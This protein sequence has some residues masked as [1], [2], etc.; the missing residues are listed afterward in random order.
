[1]SLLKLIKAVAVILWIWLVPIHPAIISVMCLPIVDLALALVLVKRAGTPITSTGLKRTVAKILMYELATI[2]AFVVET[3]LLSGLVP[4]V[5]LVTG[6]IGMTELKSCLEHLDELGGSP[7][8]AS[9]ITK[10]AP[11][12]P[13]DQDPPQ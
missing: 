5:K 9:I 4:A 6:L 10:L 8:F 7:L 2:L 11:P 12:Q 1:M 3:Y 13:P